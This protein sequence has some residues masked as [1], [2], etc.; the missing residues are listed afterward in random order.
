[1]SKIRNKTVVQI[2]DQLCKATLEWDAESK[3]FGLGD[4]ILKQVFEEDDPRTLSEIT[5]WA[6]TYLECI[7]PSA[8]PYFQ[9]LRLYWIDDTDWK[10]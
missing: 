8:K 6:W 3:M 10:Y 2:I 1:M 7:G 5:N 9:T 4:Y